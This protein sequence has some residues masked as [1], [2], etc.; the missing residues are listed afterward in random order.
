MRDRVLLPSVPL[1]ARVGCTEAERREPQV[2]LVDIELRCD[3]AAAARS[4]SIADAVD[5]VLVRDEAERVAGRRPYA[6]VETIADGIAR[7]LLEVCPASEALVRVRKP[8]ALA[9]HGVPW[10]GVEV[11][12]ARDA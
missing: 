6:L 5:Y 2:V 12:R 3:V 11:V 1:K 9:R 8:S 4:D 7:R 10:A